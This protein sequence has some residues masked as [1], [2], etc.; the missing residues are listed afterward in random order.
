VLLLVTKTNC[1]P[2]TLIQHGCS[3]PCDQCVQTFASEHLDSLFGALE[4]MI[5]R[6]QDAYPSRIVSLGRCIRP[7]VV[8]LDV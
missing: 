2:V 6:P 1:F 4:E 5:T 3:F 7:Q 8:I